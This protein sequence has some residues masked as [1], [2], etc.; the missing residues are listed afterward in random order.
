[1]KQSSN[2]TVVT[3][4]TLLLAASLNGCVGS[5]KHGDGGESETTVAAPAAASSTPVGLW[6]YEPSAVD[7]FVEQASRPFHEAGMQ[8]PGS[9]QMMKQARLRLRADHTFIMEVAPSIGASGSWELEETP[10]GRRLVFTSSGELGGDFPPLLI[11]GVNLINDPVTTAEQISALAEEKERA[12]M[13][14]LAR[15][16]PPLVRLSNDADSSPRSL[17]AHTVRSLT[18]E[19]V[20]GTWAPDEPAMRRSAGAD[21]PEYEK[22][23]PHAKGQLTIGLAYA[24]MKFNADGTGTAAV[25]AP[26]RWK[27]EG[28]SL[29]I[30]GLGRPDEPFT[31]RESRLANKNNVI[32]MK[33]IAD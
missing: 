7:V 9:A 11:S 23:G 27:I 31:L 8:A 16:F 28:E 30:T 20:V 25:N 29:L 3:S 1:M 33:K 22:M 19:N 2:L 6:A 21:E 5:T 18:K 32:V 26:F 24:N 12:D 4:V 10:Q 17:V 13:L 15:L 14:A